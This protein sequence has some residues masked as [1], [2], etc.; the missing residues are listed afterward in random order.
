MGGGLA[1]LGGLSGASGADRDSGGRAAA[2]AFARQLSGD[3]GQPGVGAG[4]GKSGGAGSWEGYEEPDA[5]DRAREREGA[6]GR[7]K[8]RGRD[9]GRDGGAD[10]NGEGFPLFPPRAPPQAAGEGRREEGR[11]APS[12]GRRHV[13]GPSILCDDSFDSEPQSFEA[14]HK[15]PSPSPRV[16][17]PPPPHYLASPRRKSSYV[18]G[19][20][21][22]VGAGF[23]AGAGAGFGAG[24]GG[25]YASP[26]NSYS[27]PQAFASPSTHHSSPSQSSESPAPRGLGQAQPGLGRMP[28]SPS[29]ASPGP[30]HRAPHLSSNPYSSP[31]TSNSALYSVGSGGSPATAGGQYGGGLGS[32]GGTPTGGAVHNGHWLPAHLQTA[33]GDN[34]G[35]CVWG[36]AFGVLQGV[37]GGRW[38]MVSARDRVSRVSVW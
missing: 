36:G 24:A 27:S 22:G 28:Y 1:P 30:P 9:R 23:G 11:R 16:A 26:G 29:T 18:P 17:Q 4:V 3:R 8:S 15:S 35:E 37:A 12:N 13:S 32:G 21:T 14:D 5:R 38:C 7:A 2:V 34:Q 25:P 31:P 20:L 10:L 33:L 6:A 19:E